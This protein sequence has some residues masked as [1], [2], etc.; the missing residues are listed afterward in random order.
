MKVNSITNSNQISKMT[1]REK[2]K[3]KDKCQPIMPYYIM[4]NRIYSSHYNSPKYPK[5]ITN[6]KNNIN[7]N[8]KNKKK[9][10]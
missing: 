10:Y 6:K 1:D 5:N 7:I 4:T 9:N 3:P 2:D 8:I